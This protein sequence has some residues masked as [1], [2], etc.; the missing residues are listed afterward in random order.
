[1]FVLIMCAGV[2][3]S[4]LTWPNG[5]PTH[6]TWFWIRLL[7]LPALVWC[8]TF[9]LR[10]H[11]YDE[12]T[13]RLQ[14]ERD[15]RAE[16][17]E[18]ALRF[19]SEPL[20]VLGCAYLTQPGTADTARKIANGEL[21]L[22]AQTS[23]A[24]THAVRHTALELNEDENENE[25]GRYRACFTAL[26]KQIEDAVAAIPNRI[27]LSVRLHLPPDAD[28]KSLL[29]TW[30]SCWSER[31]FRQVQAKPLSTKK[32]MMALDEWL[33]I[34]GGPSLER[35][36]LFVSVQLHD[37]PPQSS[38]E[39]AVGILF[40]W[41]PLADRYALRT[42]AML[43]RPVEAGDSGLEVALSKVLQWGKTLPAEIRDLW[44]AGLPSTEKGALVQ[45][46]SNTNLAVS[47]TTGLTGV[48]DVDQA[49]GN[50]GVCAGWLATALAIEHAVQTGAPQLIAS[51][52]GQLRLAVCRPSRA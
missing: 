43:H 51:H 24:G 13:Q 14:A 2:L 33:D 37:S 29:N 16:D 15:V 52:E 40:A 5:E 27:P 41:A 34:R 25:P 35:A 21:A 45:A 32:G 23:H 48:H 19:A 30:Q 3:I 38:A 11:Y 28:Q 1:M 42:Q 39:A 10:L 17:R 50:P 12:E 31:N 4:L 44:Q 46:A 22:V 36:T 26:L 6:T 8:V 49:I 47:L 20:A 18:K 9:G 7:A